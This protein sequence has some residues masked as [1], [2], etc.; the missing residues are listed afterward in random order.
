MV[1]SSTLCV[2]SLLFLHSMYLGGLSPHSRAQRRRLAREVSSQALSL[3][4]F[5]LLG[6]SSTPKGSG[7]EEQPVL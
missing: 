2:S 1:R 3:P 4:V 5:W 7:P 6:D